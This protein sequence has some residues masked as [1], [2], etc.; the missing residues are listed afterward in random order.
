MKSTML[1]M[2]KFGATWPTKPIVIA[3]FSAFASCSISS[4]HFTAICRVSSKPEPGGGR[5]RSTN[6]PESIW[7]NSS[8]P[9]C[10]P[11]TPMT[12]A[13]ATEIGRT[14]QPRM[15]DESAHHLAVDL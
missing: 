9:I 10:N 5:N 11:S 13:D 4:R 2:P 1:S 14:R 8:V 12:T 3:M 6:C 7:G 15:P